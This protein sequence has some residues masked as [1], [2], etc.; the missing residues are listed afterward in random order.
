[1][2]QEE[3]ELLSKEARGFLKK[4]DADADEQE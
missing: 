1:L 4:D 3:S 2:S